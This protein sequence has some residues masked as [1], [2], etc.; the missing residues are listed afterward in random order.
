VVVPV[1]VHEN[2]YYVHQ[3]LLT[4]SSMYFQNAMKP[5]WRT[6]PF[7]PIEVLGAECAHFEKYSQWLYTKQAPV[8]DTLW[9]TVEFAKLYVF[10][11]QIMDEMY[12][13]VVLSAMAN[14]SRSPC[15]PAIRTIYAGTTPVSP[16]R[17]LM[18][19]TSALQVTSKSKRITTLDP[20]VDGEFMRDLVVAMVRFRDEYGNRKI[21]HSAARMEA[22]TMILSEDQGGLKEVQARTR[23]TPTFD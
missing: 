7:K 1:L 19:Y 13:C 15:L 23:W 12:Q 14:A 3:T 8:E 10:A 4:S 20:N 17:R 11:E 5:E 9:P 16:A 21:G 22:Y 2:T 6:D 18:A